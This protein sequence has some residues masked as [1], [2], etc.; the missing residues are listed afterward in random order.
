MGMT[1]LIPSGFAVFTIIITIIIM[2]ISE[3]WWS[4]WM[5]HLPEDDEDWSENNRFEIDYE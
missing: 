5:L 2:I 1:L 4:K 3:V